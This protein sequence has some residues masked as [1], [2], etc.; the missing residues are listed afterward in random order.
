MGGPMRYFSL[1]IHSTEQLM[2]HGFFTI[3]KW[4]GNKKRWVTVC[5]LNGD[6]SMTDALRQLEQRNKP[7]FFRIIQTQRMIWAEKTRGKLMLRKWHASDPKTLSENGLSKATSL[8][9]FQFQKVMLGA[10]SLITNQ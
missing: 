3:E 9:A 6:E 2:A 1:A 7:G 10:K 8:L 5:H 4:Q